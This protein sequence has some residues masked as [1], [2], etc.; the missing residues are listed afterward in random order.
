MIPHIPTKAG[1]AAQPNT[2]F[3]IVESPQHPNFRMLYARLGI[4]EIKPR[5]VRDAIKQLKKQQPDYLVA[6][7]IYG[8]GNNYAGV[9]IGNLD[10]LL[11]SLQKYSPDTRVIV[12][13]QKEEQQYVKQLGELFP[14]HS[15]LFYPVSE[16]QIGD[17]LLR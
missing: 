17:A 9:N 10:V 7:F 13:A 5:S 11:S 4:Q 16:T 12:L 6:D 2:L 1:T 15:V 3:S 14:L 8:Y